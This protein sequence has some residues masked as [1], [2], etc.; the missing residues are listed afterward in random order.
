MHPQA[1][2]GDN[3][4]SL[5]KAQVHMPSTEGTFLRSKLLPKASLKSLQVNANLGWNKTPDVPW[6]CKDSAEVKTWHL[7]ISPA[8]KRWK[9]KVTPSSTHQT[10]QY[11][12]K[13]PKRL[14]TK[15]K[16]MK[17]NNLSKP[18]DQQRLRTTNFQQ[19]QFIWP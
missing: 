6:H 18:Q 7:T 13:L 19:T 4:F 17:I 2:S 3:D 8:I 16:W 10:V 14:T 11:E 9:V 5:C 12:Q 1:N 15:R